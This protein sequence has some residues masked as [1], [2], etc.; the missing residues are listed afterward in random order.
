MP[1]GSGGI[2]FNGLII[3]IEGVV[4]RARKSFFHFQILPTF[5]SV[6]IKGEKWLRF[7]LNL[8]RYR[9]AVSGDK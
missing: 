6:W 1:P 3:L 5:G 9:P 8:P 2:F 7:P 4:P